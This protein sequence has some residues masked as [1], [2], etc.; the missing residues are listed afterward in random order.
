VKR[1]LHLPPLCTTDFDFMRR[2]AAT[3]SRFRTFLKAC[4]VIEVTERGE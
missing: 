4:L 3:A 2:L 1:L